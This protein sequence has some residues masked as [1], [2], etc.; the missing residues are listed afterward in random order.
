[1][2]NASEEY[3]LIDLISNRDDVIFPAEIGD[4][5]EFFPRINFTGGIVRCVDDDRAGARVENPC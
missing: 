5:V 3:V 4:Q 2:R 1:M